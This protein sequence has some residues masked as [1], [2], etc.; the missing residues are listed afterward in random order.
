M[1]AQGQPGLLLSPPDLRGPCVL[2]HAWY[3]PRGWEPLPWS[4]DIMNKDQL[5]VRAKKTAKELRD[6]ARDLEKN[7]VECNYDEIEALLEEFEADESQ[8]RAA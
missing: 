2:P 1:Q 3:P 5:K 4:E 6:A 7:L 8:N